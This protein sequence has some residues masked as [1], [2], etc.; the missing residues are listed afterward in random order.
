MLHERNLRPQAGRRVAGCD[1]R[2]VFH[3]ELRWEWM[4]G[5]FTSANG[6]VIATRL[7]GHACEDWG[8]GAGQV[9]NTA[10]WMGM[11]FETGL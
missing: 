6:F 9:W 7:G 3:D 2:R 8:G 4:N 10:A 5:G 1:E 11:L